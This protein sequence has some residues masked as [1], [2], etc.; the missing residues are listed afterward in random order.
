MWKMQIIQLCLA[1]LVCSGS[2]VNF[3]LTSFMVF[4]SSKKA[5]ELWRLTS[6]MILFM[7]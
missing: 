5:K 7:S 6:M 2:N 3:M 4:G 1:G